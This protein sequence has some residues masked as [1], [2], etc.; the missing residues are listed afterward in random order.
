MQ[1]HEPF[2]SL[3]VAPLIREVVMT[4]CSPRLLLFFFVL[5]LPGVVMA[6]G[7]AKIPFMATGSDPLARVQFIHNLSDAGPID[8][9]LN[10]ER[11]LDDF[12]YREA[13]PF[14]LLLNGSYRL[15]IVRGADSTNSQPLRTDQLNL[16]AEE[17]YVIAAQGRDFAPD[18]TVRSG[19]RGTSVSGDVEFFVLHGSPDTGPL[20]IRLLDPSKGNA[21]IS[22]VQNN[23]KFGESSIYFRLAPAEYNFEVTN[24]D[25]SR[26]LDV[27]NFNL[28]GLYGGTFVLLTSG[29]GTRASQGFA[30]I[31]YD[32][33]GA[34]VISSI[35]TTATE[36]G[37]EVP[38][39]FT[40]AQNYPNPFN[41]S[42]AL[43]YAL[44]RTATVRLTVYDALGRRVRTLVDSEEQP[45]GSYT[46]T[47]DGHDDA[48]RPVSSG[49]YLYRIVASDF[50]Q[51]RTML[52]VK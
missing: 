41:P 15:D 2:P 32:V 25:N 38:E 31:G 11:W 43:A 9:Y 1:Y 24:A 19:V 37:L 35:S 27:Y 40:L 48:G 33:N 39:V 45:P 16:I 17:H 14:E 49:V 34:P 29:L 44:P 51:A 10:N 8:V 47:W 4:V 7:I 20:D 22:L 46:V 42:T 5:L 30:L 52:L 23:I 50:V 13:T 36:E 26:V 12:D 3:T 6:Q 28:N 18:L 21:L